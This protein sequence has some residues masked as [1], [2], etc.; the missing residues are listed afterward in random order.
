MATLAMFFYD[1]IRELFKGGRLYWAWVV[2]LVAMVIFGADKYLEQ[3]TNGLIV[4]GMSDQ[5]SWGAYIANFTYLVGVAAA[6]VM[7]VIPAYI[8][9]RHDV[10]HVVLIGEGIAVAAVTMTMLFVFVDLGRPDRFWHLIP[11]LGRFNFPSSMLAWDVVVLSG[12]LFLNLT[13][14]FYILFTRYRGGEPDPKIY[15]P[16]VWLSIAWAI[17]I[18]TVT[19]FL[20][21]SNVGRIF[22]HTSILGPRFLAS[23]FTSGPALIVLALQVVNRFTLFKISSSV[24]DLLSLIITVALQINLFLLG[25]E[26]YTEFYVPTEHATAAQFLFFGVGG[27]TGLVPWI[28]TAIAF[29]LL[30]VVIL[31]LHP[32]RKRR[33][34]LNVACVLAVV[35]VW[36]EKG[37]GLIIPGFVPTPIGE[38]FTYSPSEVE[39]LISLGI[40][41]FGL[42]V[43][44]LLAK[45]AIPIELGTL[46]FSRGTQSGRA[47]AQPTVHG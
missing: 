41:A 40:W 37:M 6:A 42:L 1:G 45:V 8:F 38:L 29:N 14:P 46:S 20:F 47:P 44:T 19:A 9:D 31:T 26:I 4:T 43:F 27:F 24:I 36:I 2:A 13:I 21:S 11:Y 22:W 33:G 23:A 32:L 18:H 17:S 28:W 15:L 34:L 12:Y 7:L 16:G 30:A 35:G 25:V 5:V 3:L 39:V 10:K